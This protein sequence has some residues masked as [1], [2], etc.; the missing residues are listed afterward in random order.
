MSR[1]LRSTAAPA[2]A[3]VRVALAVLTALVA[4]C[5]ALPEMRGA[6]LVQSPTIPWD[7]DGGRRALERLR[8][9]GANWVA[10][11]PFMA[12][13]SPTACD[14][15]PTA[16][17]LPAELATAIGHAQAVG[18][19]VALK[20]Q[21]LVP[22]SWAGDVGADDEAGWAC[23]FAAYTRALTPYAELAAARDVDLFV[24]GT[25][26][27]R[28]GARP[29]WQQVAAAVRQHYRGPL[30]YTFHDL[31]DAGSFTALAAL[32]RV[33]VSVYPPIGN[34]PATRDARIAAHRDRLADAARALG[35]PVWVAE[36]GYPSRQGAGER[37]W[38][39][40]GDA[41]AP[42]V[43]DGDAQAAALGAWL[44]A[45]NTDW[46]HGILI[47]NWSSDPHAGGAADT[48][49]TPQNKPAEAAIACRWRG[50]SC[51]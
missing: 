25:E 36:I 9:A 48:D 16:H 38:Q 7:S 32:D 23:W 50:A 47:W 34:D 20:P 33:G 30:S 37:P 40:N 17:S 6:N 27:K 49:F 15:A 45:L 19:R 39:W 28:T 29:E 11:V 2:A 51:R 10:F 13:S 8:A 21:V 26:L 5:G 12:Q 24:L 31:A 18:L 14:L 3:A 43:P 46:N 35:K 44:D 22:G 42:R 1:H 4:G 41:P